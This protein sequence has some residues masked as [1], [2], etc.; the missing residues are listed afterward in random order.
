VTRWAFAI[1]FALGAILAF[2]IANEDPCSDYTVSRLI[3]SIA[4]ALFVGALA[5]LVL[6]PRSSERPDWFAWAGGGVAAA[7]AFGIV[8]LVLILNF[9]GSC[10]S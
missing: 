10:T 9:V 5:V 3:A 6:A 8:W 2:L 4:S 7:A 1:A